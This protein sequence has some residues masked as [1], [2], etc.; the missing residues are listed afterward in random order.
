MFDE[1]EDHPHAYERKLFPVSLCDGSKENFACWVY[2]LTNFN[3][4]L[5]N[6]PHLEIF[7]STDHIQASP[8]SDDVEDRSSTK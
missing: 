7:S 1:F 4:A 5:L 2:V 6:Q 8:D 3:P